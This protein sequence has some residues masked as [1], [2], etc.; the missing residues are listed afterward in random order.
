MIICGDVQ[1]NPGPN[2][3]IATNN[4]DSKLNCMPIN[5]RSLCNKLVEFQGLVYGNDLDVLA[6]TVTWLQDDLLNNE[7]LSART[8]SIFRKDRQGNR[9]GGGVLLAVKSDILAY[10]RTDLEPINSEILVCELQPSNGFKI[11]FCVCYRPPDCTKFIRYFENLLKSLHELDCGR[12]CMV[13][14]FNM[15]DVNWIISQA[16]PS[17][18]AIFAILLIY[19]FLRKWFTK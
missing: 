15:P 17:W 7:I 16:I 2:V 8:Y 14:D 10:R 6:V 13:G 18:E 9:R 3:T 4:N 1:R 19:I 11:S 12:I 5:S